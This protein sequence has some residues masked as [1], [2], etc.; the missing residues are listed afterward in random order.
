[1]GQDLSIVSIMLCKF[2]FM[3][4]SELSEDGSFDGWFIVEAAHRL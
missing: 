2:I 4:S 3:P 1:M